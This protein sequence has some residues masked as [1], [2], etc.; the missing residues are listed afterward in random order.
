[1]TSFSSKKKG[2]HILG[3]L[4]FFLGRKQALEVNC[5]TAV[6][7]CYNNAIEDGPSSRALSL[8]RCEY[9]FARFVAKGKGSGVLVD[10]G[11]FFF[12]GSVFATD[13]RV[14]RSQWARA[15]VAREAYFTFGRPHPP[16]R[17][18]CPLGAV[19]M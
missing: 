13:A 14:A 15:G 16:H 12:A 5:D 19:C 6:A 3:R 18:R 7:F 2:T 10:R 9:F 11:M 1:M 8:I 4:S 17:R